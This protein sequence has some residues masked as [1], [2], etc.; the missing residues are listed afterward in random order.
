MIIQIIYILAVAA[1]AAALVIYW[2]EIVSSL[3]AHKLKQD[4]VATL[5]REKLANGKQ[6]RIS[7]SIF[8]NTPYASP[9]YQQTWVGD[10]LDEQ[11][12]QLFG[13]HDEVQIKL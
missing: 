1:A 8:Q 5:L 7:A 9:H 11:L 10:A 4:D 2:D 13:E 12:N 3:S 6:V